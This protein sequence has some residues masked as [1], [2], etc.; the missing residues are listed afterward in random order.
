MS[1]RGTHRDLSIDYIRNCSKANKF[2]FTKNCLITKNPVGMGQ[3][4]IGKLL[5]ATGV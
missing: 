1:Y 4:A 2:G 5:A 3:F